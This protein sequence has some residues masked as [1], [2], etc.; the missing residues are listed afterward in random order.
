VNG[1]VVNVVQITVAANVKEKMQGS[2]IFLIQYDIPKSTNTTV[3]K[4]HAQ[5]VT[6]EASGVDLFNKIEYYSNK[7]FLNI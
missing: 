2:D 3:P 4:V 1:L 5:Q 7:N 6:K